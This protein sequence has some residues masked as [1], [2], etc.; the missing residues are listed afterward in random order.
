M[1]V[2]TAIH[3]IRSE[4][5][6]SLEDAADRL[7]VTPDVLADVESSRIAPPVGMIDAVAAT[8]GEDPVVRS[9]RASDVYAAANPK[10]R[11]GLE[12]MLTTWERN[13][14]A[15]HAAEPA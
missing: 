11:A 4:A 9:T 3:E 5:G 7:G 1:T 12:K 15:A 8:F 10:L 6:L 14:A 13:A 2:C